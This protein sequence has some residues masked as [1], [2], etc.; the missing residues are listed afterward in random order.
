MA[1]AHRSAHCSTLPK[2]RFSASNGDLAV[3]R[4]GHGNGF[5]LAMST[6]AILA[7][8]YVELGVFLF[9]ILWPLAMRLIE[10][11]RE[12]R[13]QA[14]SGERRDLVVSRLGT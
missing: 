13:E 5:V 1:G 8:L 10:D 12:L 11:A 4:Y 3:H 2:P 14:G 6:N 9:G 7:M